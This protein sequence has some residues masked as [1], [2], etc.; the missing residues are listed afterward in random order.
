[1]S[2]DGS[3]F[4]GTWT[5]R[6]LL[7]DPVLAPDSS[8]D[9]Q[10]WLDLFFGYGTLVIRQGSIPEELTGTIGGDDWSL[11]LHGSMSPGNPGQVRFQ[12]K[13]VVDGAEWIYDYIGWL[14]PVWPGSTREL[15][16]TAM[17]GSI[18]RTIPHPKGKSGTAPAGVV[19]SWYAVKVK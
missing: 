3:P 11:A 15:Q 2:A 7:N 6:S 12:G 1:M 14:V 17:V 16:A 9:P 8:K 19:A 4:V 10:P 5:Y 18:V 13:G